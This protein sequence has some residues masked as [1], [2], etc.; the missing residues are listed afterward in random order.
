MPI[1]M[2]HP[3]EIPQEWGKITEG[4][5]CGSCYMCCVHLG[6]TELNKHAGVTCKHLTGDNGPD[7]RCSIYASRPP[8][9]ST[10][11]CMWRDGYG[12]D[13]LYPYES[14]VLLSMYNPEMG[15]DF[16]I[17]AILTKTMTNDAYQKMLGELLQLG[18]KN[19]ELR[20]VNPTAKQAMLCF[21]GKIYACKLLP[22]TS[23]EGLRFE[24]TGE[25]IGT[26]Y[27]KD[28]TKKE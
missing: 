21:G 24:S 13:S 7:K 23:I 12:P 19:V 4:R 3:R 11:T 15:G 16:A 18:G 28:A 26:Y 2:R 25:V 6:I 14:G 17:T 27:V 22:S 9:C 5:K 8:A 20:L 1:P 10:Y